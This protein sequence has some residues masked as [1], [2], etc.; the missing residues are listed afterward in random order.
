M[1]HELSVGVVALLKTLDKVLVIKQASGNHWTLCKGHE[2]PTD[3]SQKDTAMRELLEEVNLQVD[4]WLFN[5]KTFTNN[6]IFTKRSGMQ[7]NKTNIFYCATIK[8]P[9]VLKVQESEILEY[10]WLSFP[11]AILKMTYP[12]D[13]EVLR[14]V[15]AELEKHN[16]L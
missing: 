10:N 7:V 15:Q 11:D 3:K 9:S 8:D 13:Q 6:Y 12:T 14:E 16:K 4:Q 1:R 5:S 2:E